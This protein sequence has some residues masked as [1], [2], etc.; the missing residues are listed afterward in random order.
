MSHLPRAD[1]PYLRLVHP[2]RTE[3]TSILTGNSTAFKGALADTSSYIRRE[4]FLAN[5]NLTRDDGLTSWILVDASEPTTTHRTIL[6]SCETI[7]K[8]ALVA[9]RDSDGETTDVKDGLCHGVASV[10]TPPDLRGHGYAGRMMR[11]LKLI[12]KEWQSDSKQEVLFSVLYSDIGKVTFYAAHGW[13]PYP[14]SHLLVPVSSAVKGT[15]TSGLPSSRPL[16]TSSIEELCKADEEIL[17]ESLSRTAADSG[18]TK[19]QV[20]LV[21]DFKTISWHLAR[22]NFLANEL[23]GSTPEING[24]IVG[25]Q[26]G[27]R[28]WCIWTRSWYDGDGDKSAD[29]TLQIL[30]LVVEAETNEEELDSDRLVARQVAA[31]L[32][33]AQ[34]EA[35]KWHTSAVHLWNPSRIALQAADRLWDA[36]ARGSSGSSQVQVVD[37]VTDNI[38]SLLWYGSRY[39]Q[40]SVRDTSPLLLDWRGNEKYGWC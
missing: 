32:L 38:A 11:E 22:Q 17:R 24:A 30:R 3:T 26:A 4:R 18:T 12:L 25:E 1:S 21:P 39:E 29:N 20:A 35:A 16:R 13:H 7:R 34:Q 40:P 10:F 27:R 2:T 33:A 31:L 37:R 14:S 5:Q 9:Y 28:A 15:A 8:E 23:Y 36:P 6:S 19:V